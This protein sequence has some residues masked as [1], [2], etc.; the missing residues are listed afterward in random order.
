MTPMM[1]IQFSEIGWKKTENSRESRERKTV[2]WTSVNQDIRRIADQ[3][4]GGPGRPVS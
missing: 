1:Q 3:D 2:L 4:T